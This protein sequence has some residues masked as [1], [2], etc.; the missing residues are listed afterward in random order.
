MD[1]A[2]ASSEYYALCFANARIC[3]IADL[4][5]YMYGIRLIGYHGAEELYTTSVQQ[6]ECLFSMMKPYCT[7][8]HITSKYSI[9]YMIRRGPEYKVYPATSLID[10]CKYEIRSIDKSL[11]L[12]NIQIATNALKQLDILRKLNHPNLIKLYEVYEDS[13]HLHYVMEYSNGS[14]LSNYIR[15]KGPL[16]E[17]CIAKIIKQILSALEYMHSRSL[18]HRD[19]RPE[20]FIVDN[21][22]I[23][24]KLYNFELAVC[25][26]TNKEFVKCGCPGYLAPEIFHEYG[27]S[28]K[29]DIFSTGCILY[30]MLMG[31]SLFQGK[32]YQETLARNISGHANFNRS[33][34][35]LISEHA[36]SIIQRMLDSDPKQRHDASQLLLTD[37][38]SEEGYMQSEDNRIDT[39]IRKHDPS[40]NYFSED[41]PFSSSSVTERDLIEAST[42][43]CKPIS[44][45]DDKLQLLSESGKRIGPTGI[46]ASSS[47]NCRKLTS[48]TYLSKQAIK[49]ETDKV[50]SVPENYC[51]LMDER[52]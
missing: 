14:L 13:T 19:I 48:L 25:S 32:T 51:I 27:Y 21:D 5:C 41:L 46:K 17:H 28:N 43:I 23:Q 36:K 31:F 6:Q 26:P 38:I 33:N 9:S 8:L 18:I 11:L 52:V 42:K 4:S 12:S 2:H 34:W 24:I 10:G 29:V 50:G 49:L 37:W 7:L 20:Y 16:S 39:N 44:M 22:S 47:L 35:Q 45:F 1:Q 15:N 30:N 40:L 3:K